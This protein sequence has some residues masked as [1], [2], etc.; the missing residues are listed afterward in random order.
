MPNSGLYTYLM[1]MFS[2]VCVNAMDFNIPRE[3]FLRDQINAILDSWLGASI[4]ALWTFPEEL[5]FPFQQLPKS[6]YTQCPSQ[7]LTASSAGLSGLSFCCLRC[8]L[9]GTSLRRQTFIPNLALTSWVHH[10]AAGPLPFPQG[11]T[12]SIAALAKPRWRFNR[13]S[14]SVFEISRCLLYS[15]LPC[16]LAEYQVLYQFIHGI[17]RGFSDAFKLEALMSSL[18][19]F[20]MFNDAHL[21][22]PQNKCMFSRFLLC[23]CDSVV[24]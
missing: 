13:Q 17:I 16:F 14:S 6:I 9:T 15:F 18:N 3:F 1:I 20:K 2:I 24:P 23:L 4:P 12:P 22:F 21:Y 7:V 5:H 8:M 11:R 19:Y 10:H